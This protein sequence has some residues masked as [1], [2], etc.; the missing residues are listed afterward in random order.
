VRSL[1][2]KPFVNRGAAVELQ[3]PEG[4]SLDL[5]TTNG[6]VNAAGLMGDI[7]ARTSNG[8]IQTQN[9]R[10]TLDLE[11]SNGSVTVEGGVGKARIKTSN[12]PIDVAS[13][14]ALLDAHTSNGRIH[15]R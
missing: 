13:D 14:K 7:V 6:K 11:T 10:G 12:G 4:S 3:V 15:F 2:P 5:H 1:N 8:A 9:S